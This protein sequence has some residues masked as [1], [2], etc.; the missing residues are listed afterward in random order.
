MAI[1]ATIGVSNAAKAEGLQVLDSDLTFLLANRM[2]CI[3][4]AAWKCSAKATLSFS[5]RK[6]DNHGAVVS[7]G[8]FRTS[9]L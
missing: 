7:C 3:Y 8:Y 6:S 5:H 1:T 2:A 9:H 4:L